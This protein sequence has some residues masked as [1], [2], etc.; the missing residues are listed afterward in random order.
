MTDKSC[1]SKTISNFIENMCMMKKNIE[2]M[3][4]TTTL[5]RFELV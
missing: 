3:L 1:M 2:N 4:K 5:L